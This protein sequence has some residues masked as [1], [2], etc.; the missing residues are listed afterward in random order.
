MSVRRIA[1][2]VLAFC[3]SIA[4][5]LGFIYKL[6]NKK[7]VILFGKYDN[8]AKLWKRVDSCENKGLTE[9]ALK[10]VE[11]IYG[12]AKTENNAPQFVKSVIFKLKY[13]Q[14]KEE[15]S[16]EKNIND[17]TKEVA[18]A[19]FPIK[20]ILQSLLADA[21]WQYYQQNRWKF[22]NRSQTVSFNKEDIATWDLKAIINGCI[23]NYKESLQSTDSLKAAKLELF[24]DIIVKGTADTRKWRPTLYDFLAHRALDFFKNSEADVTKAAQQFVVNDDAYLKPY[25]EFLKLQ[26]TKPQDSLELKYYAV[27][28]FQDLYNFNLKTENVNGVLDLELERL[29]FINGYSKN[30]L[31]DSLYLQTLGW[32]EKEFATNPR[33]SEVKYEVAEWYLQKSAS[34]QPLNSND[35]KEYKAKAHSICSEIIKQHPKTRGAQM[36][37]NMLNGIEAVSLQIHA[38][39]VNDLNLP[40]RV[41]INYTNATKLYFKLVKTDYFTFRNYQNKLYGEKLLAKLLSLP[42]VLNFEQD[43]PS[44]K[45][46]NPHS[47]E[48]KVPAADVG[49]YMLLASTKADFTQKENT[50]TFQNY[51]VS[52]LATL[53]KRKSNGEYDFYVLNRTTGKPIANASIQVWHNKY[54]YKISEYEFKKGNQFTTDTKGYATIKG[55]TSSDEYNFFV[56]VKS[57]NDDLISNDNFYSYKDYDSYQTQ[58]QTSIFTDRA[59]YRPGQTVY[60]KAI[61]LNTSKKNK[62][63]IM[64]NHSTHVTFYDVNYQKISEQTLTTN[65]Y[66][67]VSGSFVAPQG[68]LTGQMTITDGYGTAYIS[69]EEYKRPKFETYF[70]TLKG[71][72]KLNDDVT[73]KGI[74]KAYA[75]NFVDGADVKYR[76]VRTVNYPYWW[77]WYRPYYSQSTEVEI[78]N[79]E[80]KTNEK[81]EYEIKF[82]A[83]PDPTINKKDNPNYTYQIYADVTDINGETQSTQTYFKVGYQAIE[84]SVRIPEIVNTQDLPKISIYTQNLNGVEEN[85]SGQLTV[86]KL[87]QPDKVFRKRLW[88]Q[89]DKHL[90]TKEEYYKLFPNDLFADET[91][92][93]KWEKGKVAF[94]KNFDTKKDKNIIYNEFK[95]LP[96]GAYII[97]GVCK[98]KFGA[99]VKSINYI[100]IYNPTSSELPIKSA[101]W[102]LPLKTNCE[103]LQ[104]AKF[105]VASSY[106]DVNLIYEVESEL[107]T[108]TKLTST[109]LKPFEIP[110]VEANRG[111]LIANSYFVKFGRVYNYQQYV[112]VPFTNKELDIQYSTFRNKLLP[113]QQE[114][115]KLT[116]KNKKG[117]KVAAEM[118]A[119]M[120]DAS[121]DAFRAN[122]WSFNPYSSFYSKYYWGHSLEDQTS[123][124]V[125]NYYASKYVYVEGLS[126]DYLNTFGLSYY[127]YGYRNNRKFRA[128]KGDYDEGEVAKSEAMPMAAAE[129]S[130][131]KAMDKDQS[132]KKKSANKPGD[133]LLADVTTVSTGNA[134]ALGGNDGK[135]NRDGQSNSSSGVQ[136]RKNFNETAFFF[137]QL[138]TNENGEVVIKFTI[139]ESLTKWKFMGFAHTKDLS[140]AQTQNE[141][142]T[143]KELMVQP[144]PPRFL[145]END[146]L[147]FIS[148]VVNLSDKELSGQIELKLYDA[149]TEKEISTKMIEAVSGPFATIG[150]RDFKIAKGQS[151]AI[152]WGLMIP[153]GYQ[154]IKYK[155]VAKAGNYSDGEEMPI[156]VLTNRMLVTESMPLPIRSN[157]TKDFTF[158]KF[159]NQNNNSNTLKNHAYTLE[160]TANPAWYAVQSLPYLMEYPY[161]CNEQTFARYYSNALAS[162]VANSKPKIKQIFESWK[163]NSPETFL[164]NLEKNQELKAV[165]LEETPWVLQS[166]NE[167]ENKKRVGLLFDL[168]KM[169]NELNSAFIKLEKAQTVNGG[170]PWFKGAPEDWYITQYIATGF[171]HLQKLGVV[172]F[173]KDAKLKNMV[174]KAVLFCDNK[175]QQDYEYM[176]RYDKD[177]LKNNH[178]G[179]MQIQFLY[180][181]SYFKDLKIASKN[182]ESVEYYKKQSAKY[183]LDNS[184]YMQG[185]IAL[186][187][188]RYNDKKTATDI[189][190]SLKENSLNNEEMGMY[191]KENYGGYYW[192]QAPIEM[193]ALMIEAFDEVSADLKA[194]DDLKTWLIK[195]K[196]TQ[197]WGTTRATTEA[198]Y[199]LLLRGTDWLSTE[200]NVE[201]SLGDIKI[202]PKTDKDLKVEAGTGYFKKTFTGSDIKPT[203]GNVKVVKK[204]AGVSWGSVYWQY[205]EQLDK[206]TPH[207]TP[208][209]LSRKL[210]IETYTA[211]GPVITPISAS[212]ILKVGDK[213]KVRIELKVDRDMEYVHLKDMRASGF[214]PTNVFSGYRYQDG[215]G[216]YEAT[217][218]ASTNFFISYLPKGTY[219]FEYPLVVSHSGNFSN[220]ISSIQ[221][222]YAP[223]FTSHSEGIRVSVQPK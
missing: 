25:P 204:D 122:Y 5:S 139:P 220:G 99:E 200:P 82:K 61:V 218:D 162:H 79:D 34:Y 2:L 182:N 222:M 103:P 193:Q 172:D 64:S 190:K 146:K 166:K 121:L 197:N 32:L 196:Q 36:A 205:F 29:S 114:E 143:Q 56:E 45:D 137:P 96:Q 149:L 40:N 89:P 171:A 81:G 101:I 151:T 87:V 43:L 91:N 7:N 95:N 74:A 141:V 78:T 17:L 15:F 33:V 69:V 37:Q 217:K 58:I 132:P 62:A 72:Y 168:N 184:R 157:Q 160:F 148:K 211:S 85:T 155:L 11:E 108:E 213:I 159:I 105:I 24:D 195:S 199:A 107:G 186:Y 128:T 68:V 194:V 202:D 12:R 54:N 187:M 41:L 126:Y 131:E 88:A 10:I 90:F 31:K 125:L 39:Q 60:F 84:L 110:I 178:L 215:L 16:Q 191:W 118:L 98:D 47:V 209:K 92:K 201:I 6:K 19:K 4:L 216:Y 150:T 138:Q 135:D 221:C 111:G 55:S 20:P 130:E 52:D 50:I 113:G 183:W 71:S 179:Y 207:A 164:S 154:A 144:N 175:L 97:E 163:M 169:S 120:Y 117:D 136:V 115:W 9:S 219:V 188:N 53:N 67:T 22:Y 35:Y 189:M 176:K 152:S 83:L 49:Y 145:R 38:E 198:V 192:Y 27:N 73:V 129:I 212:T 167:S 66:G 94:T 104:T 106:T 76:V 206:I 14:Y 51:V 46:F 70:D 63:E 102:G 86:Y 153:E 75:G 133:G 30:E 170:W 59:I 173:S 161:E 147:T 165:V 174:E 158:T 23:H 208:L 109:S 180:M 1:I 112:T 65:E 77:Y 48:V 214:E 42:T 57:G 210:F 44:D 28:L 119:G 13:A 134:Q 185:M 80:I 8:Y 203:M 140:Y 123:S 156:P 21:Y 26:I 142:V 127:N 100:T 18:T 3:A 93:Y 116:I 223:E 177:Y 181:R 124:Q